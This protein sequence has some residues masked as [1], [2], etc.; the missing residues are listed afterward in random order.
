V[1]RV[2]LLLAL[3]TILASGASP[4]A[5][6]HSPDTC[7]ANFAELTIASDRL[8]VRPG[9]TIT[10]TVLASNQGMGTCDVTAT[11]ATVTLPAPNG[12][13]GGTTVPLTLPAGGALPAG[14]IQTAVSTVRYTVAV[15]PGVSS[16]TARVD[17][18]GVI[19]N[20]TSDAPATRDD[21]VGTTTTQRG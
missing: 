12:T 4:A 15:N 19:H 3:V 16:V 6:H 5:A 7:N 10:Y 20:G 9:D 17:A 14:T 8:M 13:A 2:G 1:R 11:S 18:T 21:D